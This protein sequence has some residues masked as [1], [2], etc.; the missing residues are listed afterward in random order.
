MSRHGTPESEETSSSARTGPSKSRYS[1]RAPHRRQLDLLFPT[2]GW[3]SVSSSL[4]CEKGEERG[5]RRR[6]KRRQTAGCCRS[7]ARSER[8]FLGGRRPHGEQRKIKGWRESP[9][10]AGFPGIGYRHVS[11]GWGVG[12]RFVGG[13]GK[14]SEVRFFWGCGS[15]LCSLSSRQRIG[16]PVSRSWNIII[17]PSHRVGDAKNKVDETRLRSWR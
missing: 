12:F 11:A 5:G 15:S 9:K 3:S 7:L 13:T 6:Q 1:R 10:K 8:D 2:A 17:C 16:A 4:S 14:R